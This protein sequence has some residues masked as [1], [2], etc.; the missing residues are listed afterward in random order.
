MLHPGGR[1]HENTKQDKRLTIVLQSAGLRH[2]PATN[3]F[4]VFYN[5]KITG[6]TA[7]GLGLSMSG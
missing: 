3:V 2:V 1:K 7:W 4:K 5:I 6:E